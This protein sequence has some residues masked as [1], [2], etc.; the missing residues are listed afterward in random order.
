MA[1]KTI[2]AEIDGQQRKIVADIPDDATPQEIESAVRAHM[3]ANQPK[4]V[5]DHLTD[6][7]KSAGEQLNPVTMVKGLA[8]VVTNF[9]EAVK[10]YGKQNEELFNKSSE[11]FKK[12][13]YAEGVRHGLGY[14]MNAVP[15]LGSTADAAGDEMAKGNYGKGL[16]S[17]AGA[18]LAIA[19]PAA[20][21]KSIPIAKVGIE[22]GP[23]ADALSFAN[24]RDIPVNLAATTDNPFIK[25]IQQVASSTVGGSTF[26]TPGK[27]IE[28]LAMER[29]A[30]Q[31]ASEA[32]P[33]FVAPASAGRDLGIALEKRASNFGADA[34]KSYA[35][36]QSVEGKPSNIDRVKVG[37]KTQ[38]GTIIDPSTGQPQTTTT[39][40]YKDIPMAVDVSGI[41]TWAAPIL[42]K[43][44]ERWKAADPQ[45]AQNIAQQVKS[46]E[47]IVE[48]PDMKSA[49]VAE[50]DLGNLKALVRN[51]DP[52]TES[53]LRASKVVDQLQSAIDARVD[54]AD[55]RALSELQNA[56][57]KWATKAD[58]EETLQRLRDEPVQ[59]FDQSVWKRDTGIEYLKKIAQYAPAEMPKL[60]R[61][62][63]EDAFGKASETGKFAGGD[64]LF[65]TWT[66]L[67]AE[68]KSILFPNASLRADLNDFFM[69]AKRL[70]A[71]ANTSGTAGA[72]LA[73]KS[74]DAVSVIMA[75]KGNPEAVLGLVSPA[76]ITKLMYHPAFVKAL[77]RGMSL[78]VG[79]PAKVAAWA[80][81]SSMLEAKEKLNPATS[82][83]NKSSET[84]AA[85][86]AR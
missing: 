7:L 67:G 22:T 35:Y 24:R 80:K 50:K 12:G 55:P 6:F 42:E 75:G 82:G 70:P 52:A 46:L 15:G 76:V 45:A 11:A 8:H 5:G 21:P 36:I 27:A 37:E 4:T 63:L 69:L 59:A 20:I 9:P 44:K 23:V 79:T 10:S 51:T 41:K 18:A 53:S 54:R 81:V 66:N 28:A 73:G 17:A 33:Q 39:P 19:G 72:A 77:N 1:Q 68:T 85:G 58:I 78:P 2:T 38:Q 62:F 30:G 26:A 74:I 60:G 86:D 29:T 83:Q 34:G 64:R 48:G 13:D 65:S 40:I 14:L 49:S 61:A 56:R 16:G 32:H 31:L 3:S 47:S 25:G 43:L 71:V 57:A 84:M